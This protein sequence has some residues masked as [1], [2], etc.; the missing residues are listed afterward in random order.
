MV[1]QSLL[2]ADPEY[3]ARLEALPEAQRAAL[4]HER[5][6]RPFDGDDQTVIERL[7]KKYLAGGMIYNYRD[8]KQCFFVG[9]D[10]GMQLITEENTRE[11]ALCME[12]LRWTPR[13]LEDWAGSLKAGDRVIIFEAVA[14]YTVGKCLHVGFVRRRLA[15]YIFVEVPNNPAYLRFGTGTAWNADGYC[16]RPILLRIVHE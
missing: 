11:F 6:E 9:W 16:I 8:Q 13:Q 14:M 5:F 10:K 3:L 1:N 15:N 2:T 7:Q 4:D 12:A